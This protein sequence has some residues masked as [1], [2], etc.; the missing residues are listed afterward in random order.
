MS[1]SAALS[2]IEQI[3]AQLQP[4]PVAR[5]AAQQTART[6]TSAPNAVAAAPFSQT[7]RGAQQI[8]PAGAGT[9]AQKIVAFAQQELAR[10]VKETNGNNDSP[11]I[12]RYRTAT[13]GAVAGAPWCA[14]FV[15]YIAKQAGTPI[16]PG[17][18][19]MGYV[20]AIVNWAKQESKFIAP[21]SQPPQPGDVILFDNHIGIVEK[22]SGDGSV[23]TIEGNSSDAVVRRENRQ[24]AAIGYMRL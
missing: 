23:T 13:Q 6:A 12:A 4:V 2:R 7:L 8:T 16:G 19:G 1:L 10:G 14:Y 21:G 17:G 22:V 18:T 24:G 11:D 5:T 15:S 3:Q 20:P 9:T